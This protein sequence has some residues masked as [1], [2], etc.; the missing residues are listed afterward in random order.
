M[1]GSVGVSC[2]GGGSGVSGGHVYV[3]VH[4]WGVHV[5]VTDN[6]SWLRQV[7]QQ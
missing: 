3:G 4:I 7:S 6:S 2:G 5:C 1:W